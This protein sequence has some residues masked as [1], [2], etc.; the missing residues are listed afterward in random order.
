MSRPHTVV[1]GTIAR[2]VRDVARHYDVTAGPDPRD[3]WSLPNPG[4]W[5]AGLGSSDLSGKRAAILPSI[6]GVTLEPGVEDQLRAHAKARC[7]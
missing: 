1:L 7:A 4:G 2:S 6:G 3:P 5:E